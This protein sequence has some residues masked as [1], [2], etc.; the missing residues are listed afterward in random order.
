M[1]WLY[2]LL[3]AIVMVAGLSINLLSLPGLWLM[4][5]GMLLYAWATGWVYVGWVGLVVL[6]LLVIAA[7]VA[8]AVL[9]SAAAKKAG[10]GTRAAIGALIGGFVGAIFLTFGLW[11]IG[12]VIGACL[13]SFIGAV[14]GEMSLQRH[15][16]HLGRVGWAAARGRLLAVGVKLGFGII[17]LL[18]GLILAM[19]V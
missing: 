8:E 9:G 17:V 15:P 11:V 19:P 18:V 10:G 5:L 16:G 14:I 1:H 4:L 12:T 13:G 7:E 2:Y 3:L 6:L